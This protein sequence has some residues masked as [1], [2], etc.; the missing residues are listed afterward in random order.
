[1]KESEQQELIRE[2]GL[3][4]RGAFINLA[5]NLGKLSHF[6]FDVIASRALGQAVYG[7][8]S[9]TWLIM[10]LSFIVCYFGAHRLVIDYVARHK[11]RDESEYYRAIVGCVAVSFLL[12]G[13]LVL[14]VHLWADALAAAIGKPP[15]AEYMKIVSWS[16][17]FYCLTTIL[18]TATRGIK[19]MS[20]WVTVRFAIEPFSDLVLLVTLFFSLGL[21]ASPFY[22]KAT[23]FFVGSMWAIYFFSRHFRLR[24][25]LTW[26]HRRIWRKIVAFG[27]PVMIAD[28][29][30]IVILRVDIIPLSILVETAHV[31]VF[32]VVMNISNLMRNIPQAVDPILMPIV[33]GM[34]RKNNYEGLGH[35]YATVIRTSLFLAFG[36]F[37][38]VT[39]YGDLLMGIYGESYTAG[40]T[41]LIVACFGIMLHAVSASVEPALIM[42]G[43][44]YLNLLNNVLFVSVNLIVDFMLIPTYGLMGAAMGSLTAGSFTTV[45]QMVLMYRVLK[46]R[47]LAWNYLRV[48]AFAV[49]SGLAFWLIEE[50]LIR[51]GLVFRGHEIVLF[52]LFVIH[53]LRF[54]WRAAL[55]SQDRAVFSSALKRKT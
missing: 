51:A 44:P 6:A 3:V 7:Y 4:A 41:A 39:L 17:P 23:T 13:L 1:M 40:F 48:L 30:S 32:Q 28:F 38:L 18:L 50:A 54:G 24:R 42:S 43:Y 9:T 31:A 53:Y 14:A 33:V 8:F 22:A 16:A 26:P 35:I 29:L 2:T 45:L 11:D 34:R 15:V 12:S 27:F 36:F 20:L 19:I 46:V 52:A 55:T 37:I 25:L 21:V 10:H 49:G 5:G 47:P